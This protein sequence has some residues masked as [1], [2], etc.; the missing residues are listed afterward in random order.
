MIRIMTFVMMLTLL[1]IRS[2]LSLSAILCSL[3]CAKWPGNPDFYDGKSSNVN[4]TKAFRISEM[5]LIAAEAYAMSGDAANASEI[6][7]ELKAARIKGWNDKAYSGD[8]LMKE[9]QG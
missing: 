3:Y 6:L 4:K 2:T 8:A 7:N 1:M 9:I 5:Y